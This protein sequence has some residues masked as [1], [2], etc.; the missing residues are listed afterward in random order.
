MT[1]REFR[2][3]LGNAEAS[4]HFVREISSGGE[5]S[6]DYRCTGVWVR[7]FPFATSSEI[8]SA[9][10]DRDLVIPSHFFHN[11]PCG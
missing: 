2:I 1:N 9:R 5:A 6:N 8:S 10:R 4:V 3:E 11:K 7:A